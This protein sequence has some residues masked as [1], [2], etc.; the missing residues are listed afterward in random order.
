[1][2]PVV[3]DTLRRGAV[4]LPRG[5]LGRKLCV[6]AIKLI[7]RH[8]RL[9][10]G[11]REIR[12][13]DRPAVGF[14][15]TDSMVIDAIYWLGVQGYEGR[16][17]DVWEQL[18]SEATHVVEVGANIGLFTVL[19]ARKTR[20]S[21]VAVEPL[22]DVAEVLGRN[23]ARNDL[24]TKVVVRQAAAVAAPSETIVDINI[25]TEGREAPVGAH[26]A[27]GSEVSD[28]GSARIIRVAGLPFR[29]LIARADLIKIDA[30]GIEA[31]LLQSASD[32]IA[33]N[34]PT[35]VIEVL[36]ESH[37]LAALIG[38]I[39]VRCGY[40]LN[41][42]PAYGSDRIVQVDPTRFRADTPRETHSKD[43]VLAH[44]ALV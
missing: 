12:P 42:I 36:P 14:E 10:P 4:A 22:A 30:E 44:R 15:P 8:Q 35:V 19:G 43:I 29:D 31:A 32:E 20:G 26:L 7:R 23:L 39:A 38:E 11:L 37:G 17:A 21:Y 16:M 6:G 9:P 33:R 41:V 1:M 13:L 40:T 18:C 5:S 24:A 2:V 27:S 3:R 34:R 28:R 25:P